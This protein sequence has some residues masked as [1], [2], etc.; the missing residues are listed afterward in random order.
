MRTDAG[1]TFARPQAAPGDLALRVARVAAP[2]R[3]QVVQLLR[4]EIAQMGLLPGQRLVERDLIERIGVSRTTVREALRELAAEGLVKTVPQKGA[5]VAAV[6]GRDVDAAER[7]AV[8]HVHEA[9]RA[10]FAALEHERDARAV[11]QA[12]DV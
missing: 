3:E 4:Q 9:R 1:L 6:E 2:L 8:N 12:A 7:A 10:L 11:E 5:I